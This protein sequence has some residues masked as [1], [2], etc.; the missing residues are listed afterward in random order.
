MRTC[1]GS[2][3]GCTTSPG[4]AGETQ[5]GAAPLRGRPRLL[6]LVQRY[7]VNDPGAGVP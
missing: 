6:D 3:M 2:A 7:N 1:G 4:E 5:S